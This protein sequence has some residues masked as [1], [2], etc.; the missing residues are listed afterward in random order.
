MSDEQLDVID[1]IAKLNSR[2]ILRGWEPDDA[3]AYCDNLLTDI[4]RTATNRRQVQEE[5]VLWACY[6]YDAL[7]LVGG[8]PVTAPRNRKT[9]VYA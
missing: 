1:T 2:L 8:Q 6:H 5:N 7:D 3:A 4:P 9:Q